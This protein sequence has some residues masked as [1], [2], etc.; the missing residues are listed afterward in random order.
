MFLSYAN[1]TCLPWIKCISAQRNVLLFPSL[2]YDLLMPCFSHGATELFCKNPTQK[3]S[4]GNTLFEPSP[5]SLT[6][7][8]GKTWPCQHLRGGVDFAD[9]CHN[10][11][12]FTGKVWIRAPNAESLE[13]VNSSIPFRQLTSA[14]SPGGLERL[15]PL[16]LYFSWYFFTSYYAIR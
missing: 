10:F 14:Y 8:Y 4:S 15:H 3:A 12:C 11:H 13:N 5:D 7:T 16:V 2:C 1:C 9:L 6:E